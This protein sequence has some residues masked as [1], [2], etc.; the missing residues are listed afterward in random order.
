MQGV[1]QISGL[2]PIVGPAPG[3][4]HTCMR[5]NRCVCVCVWLGMSVHVCLNMC[6]FVRMCV[7]VDMRA[8][9]CVYMCMYVCKFKCVVY[10]PLETCEQPTSMRQT[11]HDLQ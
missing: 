7:L 4:E 6:V 3:V 1:A 5:Q 11:K 9:V 8:C 10:T 2:H